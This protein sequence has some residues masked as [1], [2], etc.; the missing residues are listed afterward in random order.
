MINASESSCP[1]KSIDAARAHSSALREACRSSV[2]VKPASLKTSIEKQDYKRLREHQD[3]ISVA[4]DFIVS[5]ADLAKLATELKYASIKPLKK[6][7]ASR[8]ARCLKYAQEEAIVSHAL[9]FSAELGR[10]FAAEVLDMDVISDGIFDAACIE[11]P[12]GIGEKFL[13]VFGTTKGEESVRDFQVKYAEEIVEQHFAAAAHVGRSRA[14]VRAKR[15]AGESLFIEMLGSLS[16]ERREILGPV[17]SQVGIVDQETVRL[18]G[19]TL[20]Q[21]INK[22]FV[23][24]IQRE[25]RRI[26][27]E[28]GVDL[29]ASDVEEC[30]DLD[31]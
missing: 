21:P 17:L 27:D 25:Q 31:E 18:I 9:D 3:S 29:V 1:N 11:Y 4:G 6:Y 28:E 13:Q 2:W 24:V 5:D 16:K 15:A 10:T 14:A 26:A 22:G 20:M 8:R 12:K 23:Y 19:N 7:F 30:N